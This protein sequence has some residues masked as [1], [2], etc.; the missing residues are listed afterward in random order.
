MRSYEILQG[1]YIREQIDS[2]VRVVYNQWDIRNDRGM[3]REPME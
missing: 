1:L 2:S 3:G